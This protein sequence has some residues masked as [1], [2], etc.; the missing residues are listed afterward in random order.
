MNIPVDKPTINFLKEEKLGS[1]K[2]SPNKFDNL[3]NSRKKHSHEAYMNRSIIY[4]YR[5][6]K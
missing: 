5:Q 1:K 3:P 4:I 2:K 6:S